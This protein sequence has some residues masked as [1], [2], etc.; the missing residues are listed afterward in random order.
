MGRARVAPDARPLDDVEP[1]RVDAREY[2]R[3]AGALTKDTWNDY[4]APTFDDR[5]ELRTSPEEAAASFKET[6][7]T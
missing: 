7:K 1:F 5:A 3:L 2:D 4:F 6:R